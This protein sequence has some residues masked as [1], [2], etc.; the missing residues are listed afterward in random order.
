MSP[1]RAL[2]VATATDSARPHFDPST[3]ANQARLLAKN[4]AEARALL[5]ALGAILLLTATTVLLRG[6]QRYTWSATL[7]VILPAAGLAAVAVGMAWVI[8]Y[9]RAL[10]RN[11]H[12]VKRATWAEEQ[13][14]GIDLDGDGTVGPP[15][16]VGHILRIN[17]PAPVEVTLDDLHAR[18]DRRPLAGYPVTPN[19]VIHI[20]NAAPR[21]GLSFRRWSGRTLPSGHGVTRESWDATLTGLVTWGF[22][23]EHH[24]AAGRRHVALREDVDVETM[25]AAVQRSVRA[26]AEKS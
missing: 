5:A 26:A 9:S 15:P 11:T 25:I 17:G 19:D 22:A 14:T 13:A 4:E 6:P 8:T 23:R 18:A 2:S 21:D 16:P 24:D 12:S 1:R 7:E 3:W 10:A 20:L